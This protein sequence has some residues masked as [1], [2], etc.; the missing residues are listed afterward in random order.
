MMGTG[1]I[2]REDTVPLQARVIALQT[3][4]VPLGSLVICN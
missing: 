3:H 1:R 4:P 2:R